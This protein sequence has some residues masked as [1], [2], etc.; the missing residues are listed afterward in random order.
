MATRLTKGCTNCSMRIRVLEERRLGGCGICMG[1]KNLLTGRTEMIALAIAPYRANMKALELRDI[2]RGSHKYSALRNFHKCCEE[3]SLYRT[4]L[5][6]HSQG[7][8]I[9]LSGKVRITLRDRR[10]T[11]KNSRRVLH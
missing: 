5:I 9:Y 2:R 6:P 7:I 4:H 3:Q 10:R 8:I 1:G 11:S